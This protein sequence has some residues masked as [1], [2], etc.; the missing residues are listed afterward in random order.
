VQDFFAESVTTTVIL[1]EGSSDVKVSLGRLKAEVSDDRTFT[2]LDTIGRP[3][4]II[5]VCTLYKS[6]H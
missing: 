5:Q 1:P 2:Y 6:C 3:T 4:K